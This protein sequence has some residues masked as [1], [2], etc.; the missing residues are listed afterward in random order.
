MPVGNCKGHSTDTGCSPTFLCPRRTPV[1][2][3]HSSSP[4]SP[5]AL[6]AADPIPSTRSNPPSLVW[7]EMGICQY[8]FGLLFLVAKNI[9]TNNKL[10]NCLIPQCLI[11]KIEVKLSSLSIQHKHCKSAILFYKIDYI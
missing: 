7:S 10:F 11:Y 3:R 2:L 9:L 5:G 4:P 8:D 1:L 6:G